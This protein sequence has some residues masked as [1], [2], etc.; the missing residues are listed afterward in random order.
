MQNNLKNKIRRKLQNNRGDSI[1]EVLIALLISALALVMLA[2]M[3]TSSSRMILSSK[4]KMDA[5]YQESG[6][7]SAPNA[8]GDKVKITIVVDGDTD[9][10]EDYDILYYKTTNEEIS[11]FQ[12]IVSFKKG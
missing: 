12:K 10:S 4:A 5:Y 9:P 1:A 11:G 6:S 2:S 8:T 3:I 7:Y